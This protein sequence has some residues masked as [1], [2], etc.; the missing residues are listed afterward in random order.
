[1]VPI[2]SIASFLSF[3]Y[4][5]HSIYFDVLSNCYEAF[6]IAS[7]FALLCNYVAPNLHEQKNYFRNL[8]N[9]LPWVMP[10]NWFNKCTGGPQKGP[11]RT[12]RS[13]LTWFNV[14]WA[15]IYQ[16]CFVRVVMTITAV[17]TQYYGKYCQS[18]DN[19]IFAHIWV[20]DLC[21]FQWLPL[22][23][24]RCSS[25][26]PLPYPLPCM[27]SSNFTI[28]YEKISHITLHSSKS[29]PSS[30]SSFCRFGRQVLFRS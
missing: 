22:R 12:P 20:S 9:I 4:Y 14:I 3:I 30:S 27:E 11:F 26:I 13:G 29:L 6:A 10:L 24:C 16:Y 1:M 5:W 15:S 23:I 28:S 21:I 25:S 18:S 19:P 8:R 7:F 2:Y 17:L